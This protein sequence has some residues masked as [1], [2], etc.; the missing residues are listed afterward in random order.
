[1]DK[2]APGPLTFVSHGARIAVQIDDPDVRRRVESVLPPGSEVVAGGPVDAVCA[3]RTERGG[4]RLS[5]DD[6]PDLRTDDVDVLV[7]AVAAALHFAVATNAPDLLFLH[8]GVV[9]WGGRAVVV[10]GA[11][12]SGKTSLVV[13]LLAAG[14]TYYSDDYGVFDGAGRVHPYP[15]RLS[16]RRPDGDPDGESFGDGALPHSPSAADLGAT[17]GREPL[18]VGLIVLTRYERGAVWQPTTP[19]PAQT[20]LG[21][22]SNTVLARR[23][24][25]AAVAIW[26]KVAQSAPAV[27]GRRGDAGRM[28]SALLDLVTDARTGGISCNRRAPGTST[29]S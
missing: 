19:S 1:V 12:G 24:A 23:R 16:I 13:A 29:C 7:R 11:S 17:T 5:A 10:P 2:V 3:V 6:A 9:G 20:V 14:A 8:A 27:T 15:K 21:L 25:A 18:P 22:L 4:W 28:V 26:S